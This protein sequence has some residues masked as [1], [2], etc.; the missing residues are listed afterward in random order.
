[1]ACVVCIYGVH[2]KQ[3]KH[4]DTANMEKIQNNQILLQD[5]FTKDY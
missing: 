1:M 2:I 3:I 4:N 5:F